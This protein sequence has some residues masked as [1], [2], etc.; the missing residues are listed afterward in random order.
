MRFAKAGLV[1]ILVAAAAIG[2]ATAAF[3]QSGNTITVDVSGLRNSNGDVR[4]GLFNSAATF[5][6]SGQEMM[7]VQASITN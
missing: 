3:S 5:P 1:A 2:A 7:G 4:C 6:K